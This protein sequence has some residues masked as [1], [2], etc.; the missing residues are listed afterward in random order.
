MKCGMEKSGCGNEAF[1]RVIFLIHADLTHGE[2]E[3]IIVSTPGVIGFLG[4]NEGT[5]VKKPV[6]LRL[7]EVNRI[8]RKSRRN[9]RT[10]RNFRYA[11]YCW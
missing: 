2:A 7:S 11:I 9:R 6:P 5:T 8:F 4:A 1:F 10:S 3:H